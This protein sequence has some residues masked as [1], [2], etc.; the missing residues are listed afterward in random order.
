[1]YSAMA[2]RWRWLDWSFQRMCKL[3]ENSKKQSN[4][5]ENVNLCKI[6]NNWMHLLIA[7]HG[8]IIL[9]EIVSCG[10]CAHFCHI[11]RKGVT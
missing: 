1:M 9:F 3:Y 5:K 7:L 4:C 10:K 2:A 6:K 11:F 8:D